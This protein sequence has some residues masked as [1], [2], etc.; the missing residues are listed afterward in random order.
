MCLEFKNC[1]ALGNPKNAQRGSADHKR[2]DKNK[3]GIPYTYNLFITC[4]I[5]I[6]TGSKSRISNRRGGRLAEFPR[7]GVPSTAWAVCSLIMLFSNASLCIVLLNSR[8]TVQFVKKKKKINKYKNN[9]HYFAMYIDCF[10]A[11][12]LVARLLDSTLSFS[13]YKHK[14]TFRMLLNSFNCL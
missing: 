3:E 2:Q 9:R 6:L 10:P 13:I 4:T 7:S 1:N 14:D 12:S 5:S 8:S 11:D